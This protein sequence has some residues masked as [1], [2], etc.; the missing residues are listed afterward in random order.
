[1]TQCDSIPKPVGVGFDGNQ[2]SE[3]RSRGQSRGKK[4]GPKQALNKL[5]GRRSYSHTARHFYCFASAPRRPISLKRLVSK[6]ISFMANQTRPYITGLLIDISGNLH[7]N[8]TP[9]PN[10]LDA[11]QRLVDSK[12]LFRLCSNMLQTYDHR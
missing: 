11:F 9:T 1:M 2:V 4:P 10:A 3:S 5:Q 8:S 7:V 6:K 12:I